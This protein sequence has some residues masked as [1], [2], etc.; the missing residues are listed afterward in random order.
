MVEVPEKSISIIV[1]AHAYE[2]MLVINTWKYRF[3]SFSIFKAKS[4]KLAN[5]MMNVI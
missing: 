5:G 1:M 4:F 2:S 3:S